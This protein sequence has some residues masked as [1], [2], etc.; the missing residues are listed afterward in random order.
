MASP[1]E[2]ASYS[3]VRTFGHGC[4]FSF[5]D[6]CLPSDNEWAGGQLLDGVPMF[7]LTASSDEGRGGIGGATLDLI[8]H[9]VRRG[10][11]C[12]D[13]EVNSSFILD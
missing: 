12:M 8:Y 4:A 7:T 6:K 2:K 3:T 13:C 10:G 9:L 1:S 5:L 11:T